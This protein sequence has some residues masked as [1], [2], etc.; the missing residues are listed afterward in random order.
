ALAYANGH[1]VVHRDIKPDNVLITGSS[2]VVTDFGIAKAIA[3]AR[4]DPGGGHNTITEA[5]GVIG[6]PFYMS[7]EQASGD[8]NIDHRADIYAFGVLAYEMLTGHTP[9]HDR[10]PHQLVAAQMTETLPD[11]AELREETPPLLAELV[12]RCIERD[13]GSRPQTA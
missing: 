8:P 9:F 12:M 7:P 6:T 10:A 2:A 11:V 13:A 4:T 1:G 3:A 5:G